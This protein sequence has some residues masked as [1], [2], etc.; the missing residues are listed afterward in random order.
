MPTTPLSPQSFPTV[1]VERDMS[2][3]AGLTVHPLGLTSIRKNEGLLWPP[4]GVAR[5]GHMNQQEILVLPTMCYQEM[6]I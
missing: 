3:Y 1:C 6:E 5:C 4:K 2:G